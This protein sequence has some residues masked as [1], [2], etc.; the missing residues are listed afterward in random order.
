MYRYV[1]SGS[2]M[3]IGTGAYCATLEKIS[4]LSLR[5]LI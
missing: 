2:I 1:P 5:V 3:A 4:S